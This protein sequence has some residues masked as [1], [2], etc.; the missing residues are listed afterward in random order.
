MPVI[1]NSPDQSA[2]QEAQSYRAAIHFVDL[3]RIKRGSS[4]REVAQATEVGASTV[5]RFSNEKIVSGP[6]VVSL[7]TWAGIDFEQKIEELK[8]GMWRD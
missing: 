3:S 4:W 2:V 1:H 8:Q 5:C 6:A 7:L